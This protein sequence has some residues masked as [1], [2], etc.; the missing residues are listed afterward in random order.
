MMSQQE[1]YSSLFTGCGTE[2]TVGN[3][4]KCYL[5]DGVEIKTLIRWLYLLRHQTVADKAEMRYWIRKLIAMYRVE[6]T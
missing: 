2:G 4:V 1:A 6:N 5:D 3:V